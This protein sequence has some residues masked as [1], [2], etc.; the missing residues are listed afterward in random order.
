MSSIHRVV[1]CRRA[2]DATITPGAGVGL[3][4]NRRAASRVRMQAQVLAACMVLA[5]HSL[6]ALAS[7]PAFKASTD[8]SAS[9]STRTSASAYSCLVHCVG[10]TC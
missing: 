7:V 6:A 1:C 9:A 3:H 5:A 4:C 8:T 2:H 10:V